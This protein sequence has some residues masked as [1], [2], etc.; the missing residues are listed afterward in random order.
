MFNILPQRFVTYHFD[1]WIQMIDVKNV[2]IKFAISAAH[3][4]GVASI[5]LRLIPRDSHYGHRRKQ[6]NRHFAVPDLRNEK[7]LPDL[8]PIDSEAAL[9]LV[10]K[11]ELFR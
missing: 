11:T 3:M 4:I 8:F 10:F 7:T 1:L 2:F 6:L 5:A 9:N